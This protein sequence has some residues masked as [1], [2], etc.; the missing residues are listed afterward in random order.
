MNGCG[1]SDE[2]FAHE[3]IVVLDKEDNM[4]KLYESIKKEKDD[5]TEGRD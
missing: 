1:Y 5:G 4:K 3:M 2:G